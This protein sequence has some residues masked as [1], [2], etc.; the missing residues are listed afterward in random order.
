MSVVRLG[1]FTT[2]IGSGQTPSGGY[3]AYSASGIPLIRSQNVLMGSFTKE[4]LAYISAQIDNE[5]RGSRVLKGDVLLN[6]TGASI[7]R[8]CVV[9]DDICPANVNQHVCIIRCREELH[10]G[11]LSAVLS[12][13]SFQ[14]MIWQD[15]AGATRQ[16]LTKDMI[17]NFQIPWKP[18]EEQR[19]IAAR[20]KAQ[21]A[22]VETARQ[23]AQVQ[24]REARLLSTK[25]VDSVFNQ[26]NEWQPIG[27]VAKVQ[28][29]YA[30]K[31]ESFKP[32]G[33]RLL[34]NA[35][36]LPG[37]IYWDDV[38]YID[39]NDASRYQSYVLEERDILISLDRPLIS[40]GIKVARVGKTDLPALLL[41]RV[42][43]FLLEPTEI[44]ADF[45]YAF[46]Q[47]SRFIDAI[48]GHDQSL[49]VPHI[50]PGQVE[51]IEIPILPLDEQRCIATQVRQRLAEADTLR[52]ALE[53]QLR[54]LDA[55][56]QRILAQAFET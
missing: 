41:Q 29:G 44:D 8:V 47:S 51:A 46:L 10:P 2:K 33:M 13:P 16:A 11:Y 9:P 55:L 4:G 12:S 22:E 25:I 23:A 43:R 54:D 49:G 42:G 28:S 52:T 7:G 1:D 15:Q 26:F 40:S 37:E 3:R 34:R 18:F 14:S 56:P 48:S 32:S 50:S 39:P 21:L 27:E 36:I 20:L 38:V 24:L 31:S 45:L 35:N 30:F 17:E 5:M 19:Q 6:I 53:Q